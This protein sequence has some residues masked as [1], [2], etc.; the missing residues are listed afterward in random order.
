M[1]GDAELALLRKGA[2]VINA[3]RGGVV[4]EAALQRALESGHLGGAALDVF[5]AEPLGADHP[6]RTL[7]NVVLTPHI[8]AATAE[9]QRNVAIEI[10]TAVR[11]ALLNGDYA[12]AV[13]AQYVRSAP[14]TA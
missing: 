12:S 11:A 5:G 14:T 8:G 6:L 10:T 13:N 4:D 7:P 1:I 2:I 3:A 9:A